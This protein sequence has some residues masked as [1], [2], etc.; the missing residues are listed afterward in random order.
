M[1]KDGPVTGNIRVWG[2]PSLPV[3]ERRLKDVEPVLFRQINLKKCARKQLI[4]LATFIGYIGYKTGLLLTHK[5]ARDAADMAAYATDVFPVALPLASAQ[6]ILLLDRPVAHE[7]G[8]EIEVLRVI[9]DMYRGGRGRQKR[10]N[11]ER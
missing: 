6:R 2:K 7:Y 10:G 9:S 4:W 1:N 3:I 11:A 8:R 5:L